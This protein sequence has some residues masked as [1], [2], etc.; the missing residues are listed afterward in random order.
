MLTLG[1]LAKPVAFVGS[2]YA[3]KLPGIA[4]R[5]LGASSEVVAAVGEVAGAVTS[6]PTGVIVAPYGLNELYKERTC[7]KQP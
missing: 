2:T 1:L 5:A 4:A 6:V 3:G 7:N